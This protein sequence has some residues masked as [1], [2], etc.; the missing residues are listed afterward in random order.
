M[1]EERHILVVDDD[2]SQLDFCATAL[3]LSGY[4]ASVAATSERALA[5]LRSAP[6]D[7]VLTD[8]MGER[9]GRSWV[10]VLRAAQPSAAVLVMTARPALADA[11]AAVADGAR[12]YL[13]KPFSAARLRESL[14]RCL[15][16]ASE[17]PGRQVDWLRVLFEDFLRKLASSPAAGAAGRVRITVETVL[18]PELP[19][20]ALAELLK[21]FAPEL[22]PS[23][24]SPAPEDQ[25]L[26]RFGRYAVLRKIGSGSMG[27]VYYGLDERIGRTVAL[28]TMRLDPR[29]DAETLARLKR[30]FFREAEAAGRLDHP[31]IVRIYDA[32]EDG[33]AAFIAMEYLEGADLSLCVRPEAPMPVLDAVAAVAAVARAL[34]HAHRR[35][36]IH[37]DV[38]PANIVRLAQDGSVRLTDFGIALCPGFEEEGGGWVGTPYYMSPEHIAGRPVDGRGDLFALG[39][40][41]YELLAGERPWKGGEALES[42]LFQIAGEPPPDLAALRPGLPAVL[43]GVVERALAKDP[44]ARYQTGAEMAQA[45]EAILSRG[46]R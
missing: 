21:R 25:P 37:R 39:V 3:Q 6:F 43:L 29:W 41:L 46:G 20:G 7:A 15:R 17:V 22:A 4:R 11:L 23:Q 32:G 27:S 19:A 36:V 35:G 45:L 44:V 12:D 28:K 30:R 31:G 5:L 18:P 14:E 34:D 8:H 26:R 38:K 16:P 24:E 9:E 40:A 2:E 13:P 10:A 1:A 42:I 33:P